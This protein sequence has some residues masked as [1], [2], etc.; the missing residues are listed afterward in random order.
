MNN[1]VYKKGLAVVLIIAIIIMAALGIKLSGRDEE[2]IFTNYSS[3]DANESDE[4]NEGIKEEAKV[5]IYVDMDG[6]VVNPG[7]YGLIEGSRVIDAIN[8][9]GGLTEKAFT[10][11]LNKARKLVDGEKIFINEEGEAADVFIDDKLININ[12]AS[13]DSLMSLPGIGEVYAKRIIE[14][15]NAKRFN[16]IEEIKNIQGIGDKTFDKLKDL[17]TIN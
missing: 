6:A 2:I 7:V 14:Y 9:A 13:E 10:Q 1:S 12:T 17:I 5:Y 11:N 15:R 8:M 4:I 16:S 3:I